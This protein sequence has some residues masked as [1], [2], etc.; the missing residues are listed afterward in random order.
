MVIFPRLTR[1]DVYFPG[2]VDARDLL[3]GWVVSPDK[4]TAPLFGPFRFAPTVPA[5]RQIG[6]PYTSKRHAT[7]ENPATPSARETHHVAAVTAAALDFDDL[8]PAQAADVLGR[9]GAY[10]GVAYSTWS[11]THKPGVRFRAVL[12]LTREIPVAEWPAV[13]ARLRGLFPELDAQ[14]SDA[15]RVSFLPSHAPGAHHWW[16]T[17]E[18]QPLNVDALPTVA[19]PV[20]PVVE[21]VDPIPQELL[22]KVMQRL[23]RSGD[24]RKTESAQTLKKIAD[25]VPFA[26]EGEKDSKLFAA[27]CAIMRELRNVPTGSVIATLLPSLEVMK[28]E[29]DYITRLLPDKIERARRYAQEEIQQEAELEVLPSHP[30]H[31]RLLEFLSALNLED[32]IHAL[33]CQQDSD[34]WVL[35][36]SVAEGF[37]YVPCKREGLVR[38]CAD[39]WGKLGIRMARISSEGKPRKLNAEEIVEAYGTPIEN[40]I[41]SFTHEEP[42]IRRIGAKRELVLPAVRRPYFES[43]FSPEVDYWLQ[44]MAGPAYHTLRNWIALSF[45][46]DRPLA[47]LVLIGG[48]GTGKTLLPTQLART[49]TRGGPPSLERILANHNDDLLRC[50]I[51]LADEDLPRDHK[52]HVRSAEIRE[53]IQKGLHAINPKFKGLQTLE[54]YARIVSTGNNE[55]VLDMGGDS[56]TPDDLQAI[57]QRLL[58]IKTPQASAEYLRTQPVREWIDNDVIAK[59]CVWLEEQGAEYVGRFGV[60]TGQ[61]YQPE[62]L[63]AQGLRSAI[64]EWIVKFL[65]FPQRSQTRASIHE[66]HIAVRLADVEGN[67]K[68]YVDTMKPRTDRLAM[69]SRIFEQSGEGLIVV[70]KTDLE[71]WIRVTNFCSRTELDQIW[72]GFHEQQRKGLSVV[73]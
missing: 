73:R 30:N 24:M 54:G 43:A 70:P 19:L 5:S 14:C 53:L 10:Q 57:Q 15:V 3:A 60:S 72:A 35:T 4:F 64:V 39:K 63:L 40:V 41:R 18:G 42:D 61:S 16:T 13:W 44:L 6:D 28:V 11:W 21:G 51:V 27:I 20:V 38:Q 2:P 31:P 8:T 71:E 62:F 33:C 69:A 25:G 67:W 9:L 59:H 7:P 68:I 12:N 52:G 49:W 56:M 46:T 55:R 22:L 36:S 65:M 23:W 32:P 58:V 1:P 47:A 48:P 37:Q 34:Y 50:P 17:F 29:A 45:Q 66:G 26:E